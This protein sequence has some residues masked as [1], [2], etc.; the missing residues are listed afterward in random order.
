MWYI[1][2][3]KTRNKR[4]QRHVPGMT[5]KE[6]AEKRIEEMRFH[7]TLDKDREYRVTRGDK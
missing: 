3:K 7:D 6:T 1:E 5:R 4:W 2:S